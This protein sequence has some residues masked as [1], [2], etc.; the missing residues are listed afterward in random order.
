MEV[1]QR[2]DKK[3]PF[4]QG[5]KSKDDHHHD[6]HHGHP[7]THE[8]SM[9]GH[10]SCFSWM[11]LMAV[12]YFSLV[13]LNI[14]VNNHLPMPRTIKGSTPDE[15]T[16]ERARSHLENF[17]KMGSRPA[18]SYENDIGAMNYI[19]KSIINV[20]N[21]YNTKK[22]IQVNVQ[23]P[24]GCFYLPFLD[25]FTQCYNNI[26]NTVARISSPESDEN[27]LLLNCHTDSVINGPGASDDAV[28]CSVMLEILRAIV[29]DETPL[30]HPLIFLFN[31]A[32]ENILQ[33]SH[34]FVTQHKWVKQIKAFINLEAAGAGGKE[35][36]FQTGPENP[37]LVWA[38]AK[39]APHPHGSSVGQD[40]FQAGIIPSD[41]DFRIFRD[42]GHI[43]GVDLAYIRNGYV[44]HTYHDVP[45]MIQPGCIQ[46]AG[47]NIHG[48]VR[49]FVQSTESLLKDPATYRHGKVAYFDVL[50]LTLVV[51]PLRLLSFINY[52]AIVSVLAYIGRR[53]F[54]SQVTG[55]SSFQY[56]SK[57]IKAVAVNILGYASCFLFLAILAAVLTKNNLSLMWYSQPPIAF[58]LYIPAG[59]LGLVSVHHIAK[60]TI[61][62]G[63]DARK[64]ESLFFDA[65]LIMW[66]SVVFQL[67]NIGSSYLFVMQILFAVMLRGF[68]GSSVFS[69]QSR[70][71]GINRVILYLGVLIVPATILINK[72][73]LVGSLFMA[74]AGRSGTEVPPEVFIAIIIGLSIIGVFSFQV[75]TIYLVNSLKGFYIFMTA[76]LLTSVVLCFSGYTFPFDNDPISPA[77][78]RFYMQHIQREF[79]DI[80]GDMVRNDS[81]MFVCHLDYTGLTYNIGPQSIMDAEIQPC[82]GTYCEFPHLM[83][84][85]KLV[86]RNQYI[87]APPPPTSVTTEVYPFDIHWNR[88]HGPASDG[89]YIV[90]HT[91]RVKGPPNM[92][93][94]IAPVYPGSLRNWSFHQDL[95]EAK[96]KH[97]HNESFFVL[98]GGGI[99]HPVWNFTLMFATPERID[100][101]L[102]E[103]AFTAHYK[104]SGAVSKVNKQ[105]PELEELTSQLKDWVAPMTW[106]SL[107]KN[108]M[109]W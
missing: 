71:P 91:F 61:F 10:I 23:R 93:L 49:H 67:R 31:G 8:L 87:P 3:G 69:N 82:K 7:K 21:S 14:L 55:Y 20:K 77:N 34:G 25:D 48:V 28:A 9:D 78:K 44:Y 62:K 18:G 108:Y 24:E 56:S 70:S 4:R 74:L 95:N 101:P 81:G 27:A 54:H 47:E 104:P 102:V 89:T 107:Y 50:G 98:Y 36:L 26:T 42:H 63:D 11:L 52:F 76:C 51:I 17:V 43:P 39:H 6:H 1:R 30:A 85:M 83:P 105:T 100:G 15:F 41:T 94:H 45:A 97:S 35:F 92:A 37:W 13:S 12:F 58:A 73:L 68:L 57:L 5:K 32:E 96:S 2:T 80:H 33:A 53:M 22:K 66:T 40:L 59:L 99:E 109:I 60:K 79:Y 65:E 38:W 86:K 16:E 75:C 29:A 103:I 46:R 84:V 106:V 88:L 90:E 64:L 19:M 72:L